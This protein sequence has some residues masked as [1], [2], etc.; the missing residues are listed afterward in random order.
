MARI[1]RSAR[2]ASIQPRPIEASSMTTR[3]ITEMMRRVCSASA[4]CRLVALRSWLKR[5]CGV[6][7]DCPAGKAILPGPL[8]RLT[9]PM[10]AVPG[11]GW[12]LRT[13]TVA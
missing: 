1:G 13:V 7:G 3:T 10:I 5:S 6:G 9:P 12:A 11:D 4:R 8:L 2:P